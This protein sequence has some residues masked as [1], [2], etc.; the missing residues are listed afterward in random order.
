[1]AVALVSAFLVIVQVAFPGTAE[2]QPVAPVKGC[3][4]ASEP[5]PASITGRPVVYVHGWLSGAGS[6]K[7][8]VG[9]LKEQL[10][11]GFEVFAF[12]YSDLH[13][14]WPVGTWTSECLAEYIQALASVHA[15]SGGEGGVLAAGHSMGGIAL[16]AAAQV[17][18]AGGRSS[19]LAGIVTLGTPHQG[20]PWGGTK[21]ATFY[22]EIHRFGSAV[23]SFFKLVPAGTDA[24]ICLSNVK[25]TG[26]QP[27]PYVPQETMVATVGSQVVIQRKLF[28]L[29][30]VE[31]EAA[32]IALFGDVIVPA[33]SAN[34]YPGS[35]AGKTRGTF[36]G[37]HTEECRESSSYLSKE[38]LG[39]TTK[40][41]AVPGV[42][43]SELGALVQMWN[44]GAAMDG[45][46]AGEANINQVPLMLVGMQSDCFHSR[47][48]D[49]RAA[50]MPVANFLLDMDRQLPSGGSSSNLGRRSWLYDVASSGDSGSG[51]RTGE[52]LGQDGARFP[53]S[54][55]QWVGCG[56]SASSRSYGLGGNFTRLSATVG[57]RLGAP[58]DVDVEYVITADS[59]EADRFTLKYREVRTL[60]VDLAGVRTLEV[61]A[62]AVSG[63]C[64][65]SNDAYGVLGDAY[66]QQAPAL[67]GKAGSTSQSSPAAAHGW[68]VWRH[69]Q[70]PGLAIWFGAAAVSGE[71]NIGLPSWV[72]CFEDVCIIGN[73]EQ[74]GVVVKE[75]TG[76][77]MAY[78]FNADQDARTTLANLRASTEEIEAW[79]QE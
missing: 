73:K 60:N 41:G 56:G 30:F 34:G 5:V 3:S 61:S 42:I 71:N 24:A 47:L 74:V 25:Q 14:A 2:A 45:F 22:D 19:V 68:P 28:D 79:L 1:M 44:D 39:T 27:A 11:D 76:F 48:P 57:Q 78:E 70:Y 51:T 21:Y 32:D 62:R 12:D 72:S 31:E 7:A 33:D 75:P 67:P 17:L 53:N 69:D 15:Q 29:P 16:R 38:L 77:E 43:A 40:L 20:S 23:T 66:V 9:L 37:S 6:S 52:R 4:A 50:L 58:R 46:D 18:E 35:A 55:A 65:V 59:I 13:S 26:C 63:Q 49:F 36:M 54:T 10:G 64:G 8:A